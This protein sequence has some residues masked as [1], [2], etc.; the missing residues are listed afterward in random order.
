MYKPFTAVILV[1]GFGTRIKHLLGKLPKPLALVNGKPFLYWIIYNLRF[2]GA[3]EILLLTHYENTQIERFAENITDDSCPIKCLHEMIP[4][5]TGG[6]ILSATRLVN[7]PEIF[8][9]INGDSLILENFNEAISVVNKGSAGAIIGVK[10][11]DASRFGTLN[12]TKNGQLNKFEEKK[13]GSGTINAGVYVLRKSMLQ[14]YEKINR[15]L[16]LEHDIFPA[17]LEAKED[18]R[19]IESDAEFLDIGTEASF[20]LAE[21]F[22]RRHFKKEIL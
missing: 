10:T 13:L 7:L 17:M 5:G 2:N 6:A 4:E 8:V 19:V 3:N 21:E 14:K 9:A 12:F 11:S 15:P 1:G 18:I 16:S 22:V 20:S